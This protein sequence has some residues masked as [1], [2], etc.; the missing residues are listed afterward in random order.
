[1]TKFSIK[2]RYSI[3]NKSITVFTALFYSFVIEAFLLHFFLSRVCCMSKIGTFF[4]IVNK[5]SFSSKWLTLCIREEKNIVDDVIGCIKFRAHFLFYSERLNILYP[6]LFRL[7]PAE[8]TEQLHLWRYARSASRLPHPT[9]LTSVKSKRVRA[10]LAS[11]WKNIDTN[12][13]Y[14]EKMQSKTTHTAEQKYKR[15]TD[16]RWRDFEPAVLFWKRRWSSGTLLDSPGSASACLPE[17]GPRA[18]A[19]QCQHLLREM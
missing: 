14:F 12:L 19:S 7:N 2:S 3:T 11:Q 6:V 10:D 8:L 13:L 5:S 4:L 1:M 17:K 16:F 18:P 9:T 15:P